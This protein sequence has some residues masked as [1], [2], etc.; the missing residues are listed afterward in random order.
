MGP[1]WGV[2]RG[3]ALI[4]HDLGTRWGGWSVSRPGRFTPRK[5]PVPIV[6]ITGQPR[7]WKSGEG[8]FY[9]KGK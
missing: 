9:I 8:N 1:E 7:K 6:G 3:K 4:F 2:A 5:D